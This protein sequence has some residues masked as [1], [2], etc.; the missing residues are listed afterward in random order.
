MGDCELFM[1]YGNK[2]A[3]CR[4]FIAE[5]IP[6]LKT[7]R[8]GNHGNVRMDPEHRRV[9]IQGRSY[10]LT[11]Q[12]FLLFEQL[13]RCSFKKKEHVLSRGELLLSAWGSCQ[14]YE[15]RTIDVHV[16]RLRV[17]LGADTIQTIYKQGY[18]LNPALIA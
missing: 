16:R 14:E 2:T 9:I 17:K 7:Y 15:T 6:M 1:N 5:V 18:R 8:V 13:F 3:L 4:V 11:N 12:E 10:Q